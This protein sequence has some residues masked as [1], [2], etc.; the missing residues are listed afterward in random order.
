MRWF[1]NHYVDNT[2]LSGY[3]IFASPLRARLPNDLPPALVITAEF[4]PLRDEGEVYASTLEDAGIQ[5]RLIRYDGVI[6]GFFGLPH[7]IDKGRQAIDASC[8]SLREAFG[9]V[10]EQPEAVEAADN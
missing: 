2:D 5:T 7:V 9:A 4:D 6:H 10:L 1:W 3:N 8:A